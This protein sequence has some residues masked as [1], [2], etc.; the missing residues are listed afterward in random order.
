MR[1]GN[2]TCTAARVESTRLFPSSDL[3]LIPDSR[4]VGDAT[5][6]GGDVRRLGDEERARHAR[7][8]C[9]VLYGE[10]G[11]D[12]LGVRTEPR[13]GREDNAMAELDVADLNGL[14]ECGY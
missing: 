1:T 9:V 2:A 12:V 6:F 14:E 3:R 10:V 13:E 8:L 5:G 7:A 4:D 11:V